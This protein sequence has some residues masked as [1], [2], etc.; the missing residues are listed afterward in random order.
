M[1]YLISPDAQS[2]IHGKKVDVARANLSLTDVSEFATPLPPLLEQQAI[3]SEVER[4][5]SVADEVEKTVTTELKRARAVASVDSQTSLLG[6][7]G[8]ARPEQ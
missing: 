2:T 4:C 7:I 3:V 8:A 1:N 5:L 6:E